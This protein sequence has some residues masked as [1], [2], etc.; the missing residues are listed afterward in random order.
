MKN[1]QRYTMKKGIPTKITRMKECNCS[2]ARSKSLK[3]W[4]KN[5]VISNVCSIGI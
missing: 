1:C 2:Q 4:D 5:I 3:E